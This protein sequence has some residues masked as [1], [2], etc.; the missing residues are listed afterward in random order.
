MGEGDSEAVRRALLAWY[1]RHRRALPWRDA[2]GA[3]RHPDPYVVW[4]SEVMLQQTQVVTVVP[5]FARWIERFPDVATLAA[6]PIE[7]V[8]ACW[9]GLGYYGRA[10]N[11]HRAARAMVDRHGGRVPDDVALLRRLPGIG[12]YTAG[13]IASI[14][15]SDPVPAIDGNVRRVMARLAAIDGDPRRGAA[16]RAIRRI[17]EALARGPAPGDLNQALMELGATV[18]LPRNPDCGACPFT[19]C[20]AA[21]RDG[22]VDDL[23]TPVSRARQRVEHAYAFALFRPVNGPT[24]PSAAPGDTSSREWLIA[25]R[26]E[27]GLLGGLWEFPMVPAAPSDDPAT[28]LRNAFAFEVRHWRAL[29]PVVHVFTHIRLTATPV[30]GEAHGVVDDREGA[31]RAWDW[32]AAG[33]LV[34][35]ELPTSALMAKLVRAVA[36]T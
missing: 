8:L 13:A 19:A 2:S 33:M 18:C 5:Y 16:G 21:F 7:A 25:R 28:V 23:P 29:D 24:S 32:V 10:R 4:I 15:F 30:M 17:A 1:T 31:Y 9:Q 14:A 26:P 6:A 35:D 12:D 34:G 11:L 36:P 27:R 22:R 3:D 20:C